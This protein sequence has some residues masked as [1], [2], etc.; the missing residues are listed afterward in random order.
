[1]E[2]LPWELRPLPGAVLERP[3]L[4]A[5]FTIDAARLAELAELRM[6]HLYLEEGYVRISWET[7]KGK[8]ERPVT[9]GHKLSRAL[10]RYLTFYR[11]AATAEVEQ[12]VFLDMDGY[13]ITGEAIKQVIKRLAKR[14]GLTRLRSHLLRYTFGARATE[15]NINTRI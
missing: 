12:Y 1:M 11:E 3:P 14:T 7:A 10:R 2:A 15:A 6:D 13:P 9:F 5:D 8:K 4:L